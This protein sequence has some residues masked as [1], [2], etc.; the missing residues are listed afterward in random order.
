MHQHRPGVHARWLPAAAFAALAACHANSTRAPAADHAAAPEPQFT[1]D[2][3]YDWHVLLIAP[4]GSALKEIPMKLHEVLLF[5]DE[6]PGAAAADDA[7][8]LC[9]QRGAAAVC[10]SHAGRVSA[11]LQAGSL[12]ADP[13]FGAFGRCTSR[14]RS[15]PRFARP[16]C[17][18]R[19]RQPVRRREPAATAKAA[20]AR[21]GSAPT[22]ARN[23]RRPC[24]LSSTALPILPRSP[25]EPRFR[26]RLSHG[27]RARHRNCG[28]FAPL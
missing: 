25:R 23:R 16:G 10:R 24:R 7:R 14:P 27:G 13:S 5:R 20:T 1:L 21:P 17:R 15:L 6:A 11:L 12:V 8:V 18:R 28:R 19:L 22:L 9:S 4:L 26:T 3:S 2:A